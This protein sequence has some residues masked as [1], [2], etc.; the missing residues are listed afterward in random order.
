MKIIL[1]KGV[2]ERKVK[3]ELLWMEMLLEIMKH[4]IKISMK[5]LIIIVTIIIIIIK[6]G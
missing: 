6:G 5:V 4:V 2:Q 1:S 3:K